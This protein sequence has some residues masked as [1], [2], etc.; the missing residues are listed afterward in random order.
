MAEFVS[1]HCLGPGWWLASDGKWYA[2][3]LASRPAEVI[4]PEPRPTLA[5]VDVLNSPDFSKLFPGDSAP[6]HFP[7]PNLSVKSTVPKVR[8]VPMR[9]GILLMILAIVIAGLAGAAVGVS[10]AKLDEHTIVEKYLPNNSVAPVS[11]NISQVL[12]VVEPAVVSIEC[13]NSIHGKAGVDAGTGMIVT[14]AGEVLT[15]DHVVAGATAITVYLE[16]Q[17]QPVSAVVIRAIPEHDVALLQLKQVGHNLPT[18]S[19]GNS[20]KVQIGDAVLAIG[21]AMNLPGGL[22][23]TNGIISGEGR[24]LTTTNPVGQKEHLVNLLQTDAPINPGNSG[25]PLVNAQAQ[26]VGMNTAVID[27][28]KPENAATQNIGLSIPSDNLLSDLAVLESNK[29]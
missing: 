14:S 25:G 26:V 3:Q 23:V 29:P 20:A 12:S 9:A 10:V 6:A 28:S 4:L 19:F 5:P 18:V 21:N 15:N 8:S 22:S 24:T 7:E 13:Q 16:G 27:N 1:D 11:M 2:P 17:N